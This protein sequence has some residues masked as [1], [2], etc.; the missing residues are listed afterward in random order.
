MKELALV[1]AAIQARRLVWQ[2]ALEG[3][4][5]REDLHVTD[6]TPVAI[7][8]RYQSRFNRD[9]ALVTWGD[10]IATCYFV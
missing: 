10:G 7:D 8:V 3:N 6:D 9:E 4:A 5:R 2:M 1:A